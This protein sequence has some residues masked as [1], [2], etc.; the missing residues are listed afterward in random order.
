MASGQRAVQRLGTVEHRSTYHIDRWYTL[1]FVTV[2]TEALLAT[3]FSLDPIQQRFVTTDQ[4]KA[5]LDQVVFRETGQTIPGRDVHRVCGQSTS[6][7]TATTDLELEGISVTHHRNDV[8][9]VLSVTEEE[10]PGQLGTRVVDVHDHLQVLRDDVVRHHAFVR[11]V[12]FQSGVQFDLSLSPLFL[13]FDHQLVGC[14]VVIDQDYQF[15]LLAEF[16][17]LVHRVREVQDVQDLTLLDF[18]YRI[19]VVGS[20]EASMRQ[21]QGSYPRS[22]DTVETVAV[23]QD[24]CLRSRHSSFLL[25]TCQCR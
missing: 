12:V 9:W 19:M 11:S 15:S 14:F 22:S 2:Q 16:P 7:L 8:W 5:L 23:I 1:L 3:S 17:Q 4:C 25:G 20:H 18:Y 6:V 24:G 13:R 21:L 10:L